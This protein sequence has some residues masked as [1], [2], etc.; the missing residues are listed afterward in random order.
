MDNSKIGALIVTYNPEV[1]KLLSNIKAISPQVDRVVVVDNGSINYKNIIE[2]TNGLNSEMI[3]LGKNLG[4][5]A[6]QNRGMS[7]FFDR[8][9]DW[10]MTLDQ[11]SI[12]PLNAINEMEK[13][14]KFQDSSTGILTMQYFDPNWTK[15]QQQQKLKPIDAPDDLRLRV[16]SSG[17]L[18]RTKVWNL[19]GGF[20]E[21]MFIDQVD[22][23]FD[24]K[25]TILGYKIWKLNKLVMQHEIGRVI[26]NE[27]L[28]IRL[29][30]LPP[31]ELLYN[32]SPIRE[33][34]INR[35][36]IVYSKR[37]Q[38]YPKFE[39][40]KLNIYDNILLTRKIL[41]YEKPKLKK[42]WFALKGILAGIRYNPDK[43]DS[44]LRFKD[45]IVKIDN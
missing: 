45:K 39:R 28:L 6:A 26:S 24:A 42:L 20:D 15:Q 34:Y 25:M 8:G 30:R 23:D 3:N 1:S 21:W 38:S 4:I 2:V 35:N 32:H 40:F 5:A 36:L 13:S 14:P 37:Y 22:F 18:I 11:D 44:F 41:L 27:T 10:V 16:I 17:N 12:V 43:D 29:L 33:Y 9:F 7:F 31:E 19:V